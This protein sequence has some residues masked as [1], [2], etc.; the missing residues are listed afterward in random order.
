MH[1]LQQER[2]YGGRSTGCR[3]KVAQA[4]LQVQRMQCVHLA[5]NSGPRC[6]QSSGV[7]FQRT[8]VPC[9]NGLCVAVIVTMY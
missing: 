9:L 3:R 7:H 8:C 2:I 4:L 1:A 5:G 6:S